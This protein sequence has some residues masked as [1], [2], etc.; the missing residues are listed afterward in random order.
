MQ[1][2]FKDT[3]KRS[4]VKYDKIMKL[5]N[6]AVMKPNAIEFGPTRK[7]GLDACTCTGNGCCFGT[8]DIK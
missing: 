6:K 3:S 2:I 5:I 8:E 7:L 4:K 1:K